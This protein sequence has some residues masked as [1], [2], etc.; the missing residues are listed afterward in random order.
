MCRASARGAGCQEGCVP[1]VQPPP[2][3][4]RLRSDKYNANVTKRGLV[5]TSSVV[6]AP[7]A[8]AATRACVCCACESA[9]G[10]RRRRRRRRRLRGVR[11]GELAHDDARV[12]ARGD[13]RRRRPVTPLDLLCW[14]SSC[15]WSLDQVRWR[16][17][18][19]RSSGPRHAVLGLVGVAPLDD[20]T[21][22]ACAG[23]GG[24]S[25]WP[26][27]FRSP[28]PP[29]ARSCAP[30][31]QIDADG[32]QPGVARPGAAGAGTRARTVPCTVPCIFIDGARAARGALRLRPRAA[33]GGGSA[34]A[35]AR[36]SD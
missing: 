26:V 21:A 4:T 6:R 22:R 17:P 13:C 32:C 15:S 19:G 18:R 23:H 7:G 35:R 33:L 20:G 2:R 14:A 12:R 8:A 30:D 10:R 24:S 36:V 31:H 29:R 27:R 16:C 9:A 1:C 11:G 28:P 34:P 3:A 25:R 5:P